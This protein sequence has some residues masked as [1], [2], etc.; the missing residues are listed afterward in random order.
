M[1]RSKHTIGKRERERVLS[2]RRA[3]KLAARR[4][5]AAERRGEG[6]VA[7]PAHGTQQAQ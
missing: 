1:S 5:K 4:A 2:E 3:N 6:A 7:P